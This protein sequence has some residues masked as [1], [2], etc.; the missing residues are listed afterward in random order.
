MSHHG[1]DKDNWAKIAGNTQVL[2]RSR[3]EIGHILE[4]VM[5]VGARIAAPLSDE[6][7]LLF[8]P[9]L[10]QIEPDAKGL[11]LDFCDNRRANSAVLAA[12]SVNLQSQCPHGQIEFLGRAPS[13]IVLD[14]LPRLHIAF[15]DFILVRQ[16][17]LERRIKTLPTVPLH[18]VADQGG[19]LS[20]NAQIVD[21]SLSGISALLYDRSIT[22]VPGTI[23]RGCVIS[24][25]GGVIAGLDLEVLHSHDVILPN[26]AIAHYSGCRFLE[27]SPKVEELMRMFVLNL[28]RGAGGDT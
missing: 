21:I 20:F 7:G 4:S 19:V 14:Q 2:V 25:P 23:L 1:N 18:C 13:Q 9:R 12:K 24:H 16:R 6:P 8:L 28:E 11:V 26:N 10:R 17:R 3:I 5:Q 15:P 27:L 22:L